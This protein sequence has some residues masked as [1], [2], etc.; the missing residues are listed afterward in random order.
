LNTARD[1]NRS[2]IAASLGS[3][4]LQARVDR[5]EAAL[6]CDHGRLVS[7][8]KRLKAETAIVKYKSEHYD[9]QVR[10]NAE[11]KQIIADLKT[12]P[13]EKDKSPTEADGK[14]QALAKEQEPLVEITKRIC[15]RFLAIPQSG[16][17]SSSAMYHGNRAAHDGNI[18]AD[19][20][21]FKLGKFTVKDHRMLFEAIYKDPVQT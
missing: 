1:E 13:K 16:L 18:E 5:L 19:L 11:L 8:E 12:P 21:L 20:A 4:D 17:A 7:L 14:L 10:V 6:K 9:Q 3:N 15:H 2:L